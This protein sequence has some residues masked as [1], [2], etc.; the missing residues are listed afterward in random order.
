MKFHSSSVYMPLVLSQSS[1]TSMSIQSLCQLFDGQIVIP[2]YQRDTDQWSRSEK[3][4]FIESILNNLV[5]PP[6]LFYLHPPDPSNGIFA[7][8]QEVVD[9]Q[10]RLNTIKS[11][12]RNEFALMPSKKLQYSFE[13]S[14]YYEG[15]TFSDLCPTLQEIFLNYR[16]QFVRLP[17]FLSTEIKLEIFRR[18]N[19]TNTQ[20]SGQ[21]LRLAYYHNSSSVFLIRLAGVYN[22]KPG[23][24]VGKYESPFTERILQSASVPTPLNQFSVLRRV[25][26]ILSLDQLAS[27]W[28]INQASKTAWQS[29]WLETSVVKGQTPSLVFLQ[30]LMHL[31]QSQLDYVIRHNLN[32]LQIQKFNDSIELASDIYCAQL[33]YEDENPSVNKILFT[34]DEIVHSFVQFQ[35][36]FLE[37]TQNCKNAKSHKYREVALLIASLVYRNIATT[38]ISQ[39]KWKQINKFLLKPKTVTNNIL[40]NSQPYPKLDGKWSNYKKQFQIA[41][42]VIET[43]A[44]L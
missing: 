22:Y 29:Y 33:K 30:Y 36:Y 27:L 15:K 10:Q 31:N 7:E 21:D 34:F 11:F 41:T 37:V 42:Q 8:I 23:A 19:K 44:T 1:A 35:Y 25:A 13:Q 9:G 14:T 39:E 2:E 32:N 12:Y 40:Q 20:L 38:S 16:I 6:I 24:E 18:I 5:V 26:D 3:S 17:I 4:L 43:I 28:D